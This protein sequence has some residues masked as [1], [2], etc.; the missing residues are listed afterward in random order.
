MFPQTI[1]VVQFTYYNNA[2]DG[3]YEL[4]PSSPYKNLGMDGKDI[5][6]DIVGLN[7]AL[8]NVE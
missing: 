4:M 6:A 5:G 2:D 8:A 1:P 3:N 7:Q